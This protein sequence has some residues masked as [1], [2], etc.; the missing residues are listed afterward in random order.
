MFS[1][2][3][4]VIS[5]HYPADYFLILTVTLLFMP[6]SGLS[7]RWATLPSPHPATPNKD[8]ISRTTSGL[9]SP[10]WRDAMSD[11]TTQVDL[12]F[13][14][15]GSGSQGISN[16]RLVKPWIKTVASAF[17][18]SN[19]NMRI[20]VVQY[21]HWYRHRPLDNQR[22]I[23]TEVALNDC[24]S[25]RCF[26]RRVEVMKIMGFGTFTGAAINKTV[27]IDF[28]RSRRNAKKIIILLTDGRS[29]DQVV[30]A[31]SYA[32][33]QNVIIFCVGV[34]NYD[35][36]ALQIIANGEINN[37]WKV[38][39]LRHYNQLHTIIPSLQSEV[40][41]VY[42]DPACSPLLSPKHGKL[43]CT[44]ANEI[45]S[46]CKFR[47]DIER[48]YSLHGSGTRICQ[49]R[50]IIGPG[51]T[52]EMSTCSVCS[53]NFDLLIILDSSSS[54]G[55]GN[56]LYMKDFIHRLID[57]FEVGREK[58]LVSIIRF[59][60]QVYNLW[61]Y[62]TYPDKLSLLQAVDGISYDGN[63]TNT[64]RALYYALDY[65]FGVDSGRR[66]NYPHVTVIL[67]DGRASDSIDAP[68]KRL[69]K[70]SEVIAIGLMGSDHT[71]INKLAS[72]KEFALN[73][74]GHFVQLLSIIREVAG[75]LCGAEANVAGTMCP[76]SDL[77]NP[78]R[79]HNLQCT[80]GN[81]A[82]SVCTARCCRGFEVK[83]STR[84]SCYYDG[85][86]SVTN[87]TCT[88][89]GCE[90]MEVVPGLQTRCSN[91]SN[92]G[93]VCEV[94]CKPG[95]HINGHTSK[96][97]CKLTA[98]GD[99][100]NCRHTCQRQDS[101]AT[102]SWDFPLVSCTETNECSPN[103]CQNNGICTDQLNGYSCT[104]AEGFIGTSCELRVNDCHSDPCLNGATCI[105]GEYSYACSCARG[106]A[107]D[108]CEIHYCGSNPCL[109]NATCIG[110]H[111]GYECVCS[112]GYTG[113]RCQTVMDRCQ[114]DPCLNNGT[115]SQHLLGYS[116]QCMS[117]FTGEDCE[118][119]IDDCASKPCRNSGTCYDSVNGVFCIC[120][121]G[122]SGHLCGSFEGQCYSNPCV[123]NG[124]CHETT[125]GSYS[126]TC[127]AGFI[128][129]NCEIDEDDCASIPCQNR[130]A[131]LDGVAGFRCVCWQGFEGRTC[132][133]DV[134]DC[135]PNPCN[136]GNCTDLV[137]AFR[138]DCPDGYEGLTCEKNIDNCGSMPCLNNATCSD[139]TNNYTCKCKPGYMGNNC[140]I[141]TNECASN[142]CGN[143]GMCQDFI[144]SYVC[145]C[146]EGFEGQQCQLDA[147][148]CLGV[149]CLN[150]GTC[151]D[152]KNEFMCICND[153]FEGR[154]CETHMN[155]C[156][157]EACLNG[158]ICIDGIATFSCECETGFEGAHCEVN[159]DECASN[160]CFNAIECRDG[161]GTF[162][163]VCAP[164]FEGL[165]CQW[166]TDECRSDP[167]Q[168][169][170]MC[171]DETAGF[172]C[173]CA[174]GFTEERCGIS[175][176]HCDSQ[177]CQNRGNCT[178]VDDTYHCACES[179]YYGDNCELD[180]DECFSEPCQNAGICVNGVEEYTCK[181]VDGFEGDSCEINV[182]DCALNNA[183]C[184]FH[185][186]CEDKVNGYKCRCNSGYEGTLCEEETDECSLLPCLNGGTCVDGIDSYDCICPSG[187][188]GIICQNNINECFLDDPCMN[189]AVCQD[190][191]NSFLCVCRPGFTGERCETNIDDCVP[192]LCVN[193]GMC[194]DLIDDFKCECPEGFQGR[195]CE[196]NIDD[197][198]SNPCYHEALCIDGVNKF[199]CDCPTG[200]TG[201]RCDR[202]ENECNNR[203]CQNGGICV[204]IPGTYTCSCIN[205]YEG[206]NCENHKDG[207]AVNPC[208]NQGKCTDLLN[209]FRCDCPDGFI[210]KTCQIP[211]NRCLSFPCQNEGTCVNS[212][213][214]YSCQC[215]AGYSGLHCELRET[216]CLSLPCKNNGTCFEYGET[217]KCICSHGH[218]GR[219][220]E[221]IGDHC[222]SSPCNDGEECISLSGSYMCLCLDGST[223][224]LN[225]DACEPNPCLNSAS[226][227][228]T[229]TGY[230]CSCLPGYTGSRC[231]V[232]IDNCHSD[233]DVKCLNGGT[234]IN[235]AMGYSCNCALGYVGDLCEIEMVCPPLS[236]CAESGTLR[237]VG[238]VCTLKCPDGTR[239]AS[240]SET[241]SSEDPPKRIC[242]RDG[243]WSPPNDIT[244]E[245]VPIRCPLLPV[246]SMFDVRLS[247]NI[248]N[249]DIAS[250]NF[251]SIAFLKR[252]QHSKVHRVNCS[253]G[254]AI[255][256]IC[257]F[258][259]QFGYEL[260]GP[261]ESVC[262]AN[263]SWS[264]PTAYCFPPTCG[265]PSGSNLAHKITC[266]NYY[267]VGSRCFLTCRPGY[268][269][270]GDTV[271]ECT[272]GLKWLSNTSWGCTPS[273]TCS[274]PPPTTFNGV[275]LCT[276]F[277]NPGSVCT[278]KC[279]PK[280][281]LSSSGTFTCTARNGVL[282]WQGK[283]GR[284]APVGCDKA[285][286]LRTGVKHGFDVG[287]DYA[288]LVSNPRRSDG[289]REF[290]DTTGQ[291]LCNMK[292]LVAVN[293]TGLSSVTLDLW[294]GADQPS[295]FHFDIGDY[296]AN[297][298]QNLTRASYIREE[299]AGFEDMLTTY[300]S[301][302]T[303]V[304]M[305][306]GVRSHPV[307]SSNRPAPGTYAG[308]FSTYSHVVIRLRDDY[309]DFNNNAG[310]W[311]TVGP[312][313]SFS[314]AKGGV[315]Y[316]GFNRL[317]NKSWI[318]DQFRTGSGLCYVCI[319]SKV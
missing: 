5:I 119:D 39:Q 127:P 254:N 148:D 316:V 299:V 141:D 121:P 123:N 173:V 125:P 268:V 167:C 41:A 221:I 237:I 1:K 198:A 97:N 318:F 242:L 11:Y 164:G 251:T 42:E 106:F 269:T 126:C 238:S 181:C 6:Q 83:G 188:T 107:G 275:Y 4:F 55:Y 264:G 23:K 302:N 265:P 60:R 263:G 145:H 98:N 71:Q 49:Y 3:P 142:P 292:A 40:R 293:D 82:G 241:R 246:R 182:D 165:R 2:R 51:W 202:N 226:C 86:W 191:I 93:S 124:T 274:G 297:G 84:S 249:L 287:E 90:E 131:C 290:N 67:T 317:A 27:K 222:Q 231:E 166:D 203:P 185:G 304:W 30:Y 262:L 276:N 158:G 104:C 187:F 303:V 58:V 301:S 50:P 174:P 236:H 99:Y 22:F 172:S 235:Q 294:Y 204:D 258:G 152:G 47:C 103:P 252:N 85:T 211:V 143:G 283:P 69:Q 24:S 280:F 279:L 112:Q 169:K 160:P 68:S 133:I 289:D 76:Q 21:S 89:K 315:V 7:M 88:E 256:S 26:N 207:C 223:C 132:E 243:T 95:Y 239:S 149:T 313:L 45:G 136:D 210:G 309:L 113:D 306:A 193:E 229:S 233:F 46:V 245:C 108:R 25:T 135:Y 101:F 308:V 36:A 307:N 177:P 197:C 244:K 215:P 247:T 62:N 44:N 271:K 29:E 102:A 116:C 13:L 267:N 266:T 151:Q 118:T 240:W 227:T 14:I 284:C 281:K 70:I 296:R 73:V 168:N 310:M 43:I 186:T 225:S 31:S 61:E 201:Y 34:G 134:D 105:D 117:G 37:S 255:G 57:S 178:I 35:L 314:A 161:N 10:K 114:P 162:E 78:S 91:K 77:P 213:W 212:G 189:G 192:G 196:V 270:F 59:N 110:Q 154:F 300:N 74:V 153:G 232:I 295:Q 129:K 273:T 171:I 120:A 277:Q 8:L 200:W 282:L 56:F 228:R 111:D 28:A 180:D 163:C 170:G 64:G 18:I 230:S 208:K 72:R 122:Y 319:N 87:W 9:V 248:A 261:Q 130:G 100:L 183:N 96:R 32:R 75:K 109:N 92:I 234:C 194:I 140:E 206:I 79:C 216:H 138:C 311:G 17:N 155:D 184:S 214:S 259:C 285:I 288:K 312:S 63:G 179:G 16:F 298:I 286:D 146:L 20:G 224:H 19:D 199:E 94:S 66:P 137:N 175:L 33:K 272:S 305:T 250:P 257:S 217:Y 278:A 157:E 139:V 80:N 150:N 15:D 209:D 176:D 253:D 219:N 220:C 115:C 291:H 156:Y 52:G 195:K 260:T 159:V 205:G 53:A 12:I 144:N 128:G 54:I 218:G 81:K 48:G 65:K 147:D 190:G 38:Y